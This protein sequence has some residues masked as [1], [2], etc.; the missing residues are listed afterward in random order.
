MV[1]GFL[2]L[3]FKTAI[4]DIAD[5][6]CIICCLHFAPILDKIGK[7]IHGLKTS[8]PDDKFFKAVALMN[9][10]GGRSNF[11]YIIYSVRTIA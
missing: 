2:N 10:Q 4:L 1:K 7:N 5:S 3:T 9:I 8:A 6:E 11:K